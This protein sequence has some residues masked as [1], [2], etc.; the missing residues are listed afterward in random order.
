MDNAHINSELR[1]ALSVIMAELAEGADVIDALELAA[2]VLH[3]DRADSLVV[4]TIK[5]DE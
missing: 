2:Q 5:R 4:T 3:D 1:L